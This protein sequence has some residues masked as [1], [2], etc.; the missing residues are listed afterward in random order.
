MLEIGAA[1]V[2]V[3]APRG[4]FL[5]IVAG[6]EGRPV[7]RQHH[8]AHR[9]CRAAISL[10]ACDSAPSS[11]SDRLLRACGRS[12][13]RIVDARPLSAGRARRG[14][15]GRRAR[16]GPLRH[17]I[18]RG[19]RAAA[20]RQCAGRAGRAKSNCRASRRTQGSARAWAPNACRSAESQLAGRP[21][22]HRLTRTIEFLAGFHSILR[23][24]TGARRVASGTAGSGGHFPDEYLRPGG[25]ISGP[26]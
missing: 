22:G 13:V 17:A 23:S 10:R 2:G 9:R 8:R 1:A 18:L 14:I 19:R 7:R 21:C 15:S 24:S 26:P 3:A 11:A 5:Q 4:E 20:A 6:A 16:T 25:T 12:S